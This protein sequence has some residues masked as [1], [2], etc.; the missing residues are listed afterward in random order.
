MATRV[1][2]AR[3]AP[4][5][6][7]RVADPITGA[8][9]NASDEWLLATH[10]RTFH[11]AAR[12]L[13]SKQRQQVFTLYAFLRTLDD[14]VDMPAQDSR[15]EDIRAELDAWKCWF[16]GGYAFPAPREPLGWRLAAILAEHSVPAAV[17]LDFLDGL[18]SDLEPREMRDFRELYH[19]CY[20][21][22]GTVGLAMAQV[23]GVNSPQALVAAQ[24]MGIGMQLTNI[25]R[26]VGG[27]LAAGRVY[28]P[29]ED[30]ERFDSSR[31]HLVQLYRDRRGPDDRFRALMRY[32]VTRAHHYYVRGMSGIWLLPRNCRLPILIAGRLY[33]RILTVIEHNDYDVLRARAATSFSEKLRE[34]AIAF[35]LDRLWSHGEESLP[36]HSEVI[37]E[38]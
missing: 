16:A 18:A 30:L 3:I 8:R 36:T 7:C 32:Q 34:A 31:M 33:R 28:L 25:L 15:L 26:D 11:F 37:L 22:A 38:D 20:R 24:S 17:F 1:D 21:V 4:A 10:G 35:A 6:S 23:M 14:L 9:A 29:R 2:T 12:F 19:Y 13:S 5:Q 27:D